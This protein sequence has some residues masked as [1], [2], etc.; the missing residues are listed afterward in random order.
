MPHG[1]IP[2]VRIKD[3][4][5]CLVNMLSKMREKLNL[6]GKSPVAKNKNNN[7]EM[8]AP[9]PAP[10]TAREMKLIEYGLP[11]YSSKKFT[12]SDKTMAQAGI[13]DLRN[14]LKDLIEMREGQRSTKATLT[15]I[16]YMEGLRKR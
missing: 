16:T 3:L 10:L 15:E 14:L 7:E 5:F 11:L 9:V 12:I 2:V 8:D 1:P 6:R 4:S 13:D